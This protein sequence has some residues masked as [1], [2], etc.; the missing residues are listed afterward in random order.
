MS[1]EGF[2]HAHVRHPSKPVK[3]KHGST[4]RRSSTGGQT[5]GAK[6]EGIGGRPKLVVG[7]CDCEEDWILPVVAGGCS[8]VV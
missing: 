3:T 7:V 4:Q 1:A 8:G 2:G 6:E 5:T